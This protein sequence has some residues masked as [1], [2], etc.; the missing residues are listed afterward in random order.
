MR[1]RIVLGDYHA[2][3]DIFKQIYQYEQ[4]DDVILL[5]D[6]VDSH[7][8][9]SDTNQQIAFEELLNI[10]NKHSKGNFI[11]LMGNHDFHY[12]YNNPW[13]EKYTGYSY[14]RSKWVTPLYK[15]LL[16]DGIIQTIYID[17]IN[18]TIYSHAGITNTWV[19]I[20]NININEINDIMLNNENYNGKQ[21]TNIFLFS[22]GGRFSGNSGDSKDNSCIW[23]RPYSLIDDFY[24][25]YKHIVAHTPV[26]NITAIKDGKISD[27]LL[28]FDIILSDNLPKEYIVEIIDDNGVV[29]E[30]RINSPG[31]L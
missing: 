20:H 19:K 30:R 22:N 1:K 17:E 5:G 16:N 21:N 2:R 13:L 4:P 14:A 27:D 18:K 6:Y 15:Q 9:I 23:V 24:N 26:K 25:E 12:Y 7:E 29:V 11:M 28:T 3:L 31:S 8:T 10:R